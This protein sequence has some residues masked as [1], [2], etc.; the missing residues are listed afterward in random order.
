M[1]KEENKSIA[2]HSKTADEV[3]SF[4][5]V[6]AEGL[7]SE[8]AKVRA[9]K[10]G[11]N[12]I[13]EGKKTS[14]AS[15]FLKQFRSPLIYILMIAAI[16]VSIIGDKSDAIIILF[17]LLLNAV[18][19][20][21]QEGKAENTLES[22]KKLSRTEAL[23]IRGGKEILVHD[24][25]IVPGDIIIIEAGGKV[26][27]D[28][29]IL[30]SFNLEID[31]SAISG[32]SLPT[33]KN[34]EILL[35]ESTALSDRK[36]MLFKG[37]YAVSGKGTALVVAIGANSFIGGIARD[38]ISIHSDL[39]LKKNIDKLSKWILVA[40]GVIV[41]TI[42]ALGIFSGESAGVMFSTVVSIAVSIIPEGLPI[43]VTLVLATGVSRMSK[44]NVLVRKL[45][46]IE[47]LGRAKIIAVDKTGTITKNELT[48]TDVWTG[49]FYNI[50]GA[51]FSSEGVIKQDGKEIVF[52]DHP[53]LLAFG[54]MAL[55]SSDAEV[56]FDAEN[57][58]WKIS[59]DPTE[60]AILVF[61][62]KLGFTRE[63][64]EEAYDEEKR[65]PFDHLKKYHLSVLKNDKGAFVI[66]SGAPEAILTISDFYI[67][68][69]A[70][71]ETNSEMKAKIMGIV[72]SWSSMGLRVVALGIKRN[73]ESLNG[74]GFVFTGL[75][76][77]RDVLREDA[78]EAIM[79]AE[80]AGAR[81]IMI[82]GDHPK[83]AEKIA[84]EAGIIEGKGSVMIGE[85]IEKLSA[86]ELSKKI[87]DISVFARVSPH[88]KLKII[89][90]FKI[91]KEIIAMTGDGVND[92]LSLAAA[93]L[94]VA[95]GRSGTDVAREA[96]D[97][98]LLDD[99]FGN[100]VFAIEEGRSI[101]RTIK[102]VILYLFSTGLGEVLTIGGAIIIGFPIPIL[103]AQIIWLNLVTDGFLD[104]SLAME[105]KSKNILRHKSNDSGD[106]IDSMMIQR[107]I[108]MALPMM[109]GTLILFYLYLPQGLLKAG[110]VAVCVLAAFQWWNAWNARHEST[111]IFSRDGR[112]N[113]YLIGA[114][115]I[116]ICLQ[117][118]AVYNPIMNDVLHTVPLDLS[119]WANIFVVSLL[120][121]VFEEVRKYFFRRKL[122]IGVSFAR[123][124]R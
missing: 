27:A 83:T 8:E 117:M 28:A 55:M 96:S 15:I 110:T 68:P 34:S 41:A 113:P 14:I 90:A 6:G 25:E 38:I 57:K 2:W 76:G 31:E 98:I 12:E 87:G 13:A 18:I 116:V 81:V 40:V 54:E 77:M 111:S 52:Q 73:T 42:F 53:A 39:P 78:R 9:E 120:I 47:S 99:N 124:E 75:L 89:E 56:A 60:A 80:E 43:V 61:S 82:T 59:G 103:P 17:V 22:L 97:M 51:G 4:L 93:D 102:K 64:V 16:V 11:K 105:S 104:V 94:G 48:V 26:P 74:E 33:L 35:P 115:I 49:D 36:N 23:V 58:T 45:Q 123:I 71:R 92:A 107:M 3:L 95:M 63:A 37:T 118:F 84:R 67:N 88:H 65:V 101:Y 72:D 91:R 85:E 66:A 20:T 79:L 7:S 121:V 112:M 100:I 32:E 122:A 30:S 69:G 44:K 29:R 119:D 86:E 50:S 10:F 106:L 24:I 108:V 62:E 21:I 19:G 46:A 109:I 70:D 1:L 114:T 5:G